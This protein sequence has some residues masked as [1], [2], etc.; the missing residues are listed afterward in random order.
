MKLA[1]SLKQAKKNSTNEIEELASRAKSLCLQG[2]FSR[3]AKSSEGLAPNSKATLKA[4]EELHPKEVNRTLLQTDNVASSAN[5]FS[6]NIVYE[7]LKTSSK[8]TAAGPSKMYLEHLLHA[9]ECSVPDHS[10]SAPKAITR[11]VNT[12]SRGNFPSYVSKA[13]CIASLNALSKKRRST[14][15]SCQ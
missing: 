13:F 10:E 14:S 2:Q 9:L 4:L 8:Y 3:A 11:F 5:Q 15:N 6:D 1:L 12:G 7:Q